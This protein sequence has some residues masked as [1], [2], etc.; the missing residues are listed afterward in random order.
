MAA[1]HRA[2][3]QETGEH[4]RR[5]PTFLLEL[6][7]QVSGGQAARLRAHVEAGR[8]CSNVVLSLGSQRLRQ[9]RADPA[10]QHARAIPRTQKQERAQACTA[11]RR[12]DGCSED[13]LQEAAQPLRVSWIAGHLDAVVAHTLARRASHARTR[14]CLEK[15]VVS[16]SQA[17][18]GDAAASRTRAT[19]LACAVYC[20]H[21]KRVPEAS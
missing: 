6:P 20:R 8:Q 15:L 5:P 11:L 10:W 1:K 21:P 16:A 14:V 18:D 3:T 9:M 19:I 2:T 13:A 17:E 7:L 4:K 12:Q